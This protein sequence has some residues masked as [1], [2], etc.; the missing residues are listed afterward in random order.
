MYNN[1]QLLHR[2]YHDSKTANDGSLQRSGTSDKS[3]PNEGPDEGKRS[4]PVL[5]P[6]GAVDRLA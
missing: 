3:Q 1:S 6:S 4:R 5:Q 2:H